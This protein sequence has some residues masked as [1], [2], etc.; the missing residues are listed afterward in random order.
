MIKNNNKLFNYLPVESHILIRDYIKKYPASYKVTPKRYSKHGDFRADINGNYRITI[1]SNL[2]KYRFLITLIHELSHLV[3]FKLY[4]MNIKPHG[5]EWKKKFKELMQPFMI[6][7]IFPDE[8]S[9][10]LKKYLINPKASTDSDMKLT[11]VLKKYDK[12]KESHTTVEDISEGVLFRIYSGKVFR[13]EFKLRKR[14]QCEESSTG[15]K[16]LFNPQA[17]VFPLE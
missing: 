10:L 15:K 11:K 16:Y 17:E 14:Y 5:S 12:N 1:N 8:L 4:G 3:S 9:S 6:S 7:S 13:K 2:N